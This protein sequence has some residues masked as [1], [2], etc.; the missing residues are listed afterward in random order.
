MPLPRGFLS[1]CAVRACTGLCCVGSTLVR[2]LL[3]IGVVQIAFLVI[4]L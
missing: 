3:V 2:W 1:L 4:V